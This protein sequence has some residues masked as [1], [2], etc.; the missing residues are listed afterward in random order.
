MVGLLAG[1]GQEDPD[2]PEEEDPYLIYFSGS[3][4]VQDTDT[5][6]DIWPVVAVRLKVFVEVDYNGK[7]WSDTIKIDSAS[8]RGSD[9][10]SEVTYGWPISLVGS[11]PGYPKDT[12]TSTWRQRI[13]K[14]TGFVVSAVTGNYLAKTAYAKASWDLNHLIGSTC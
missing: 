14:K 3:E 7:Y 8:I 13:D 12:V 5:V 9:F 4:T 6:F 10:R 11:E 1:G 2:P